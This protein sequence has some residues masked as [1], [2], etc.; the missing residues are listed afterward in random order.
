MTGNDEDTDKSSSRV[1]SFNDTW[2]CRYPRPRK[3][4]LDNGSDYERYFTTLLNELN[5][6][7]VLITIK[8][9][10]LTLR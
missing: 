6:K 9:H 5:I 7:P 1:T 8:N 10:N 4:V 3:G 2:L